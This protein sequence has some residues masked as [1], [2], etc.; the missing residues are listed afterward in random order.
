MEGQIKRVRLPEILGR[1]YKSFWESKARYLVCKGGRGSKKSC[2]A[3]LKLIYNIMQYPGSNGLVVRRYDVDH[4]DSTF[5]Q[6]KWAINRLGVSHLWKATTSPIKLVY[7]PTGQSII[8]RGLNDPQSIA[9]AT[10]EK[11]YL[12]FVWLEEAYQVMKESDFDRL[13]L[14]IRGDIPAPLFKQFIITFNPWNEKHWLKSRFFDEPDRF[15]NS[16]TT[17][18]LQNEFLGEDDI[19]LF[20]LM[21]E[22][23]PGRYAVEGLGNWGTLEGAIYSPY[24][25]DPNR[26]IIDDPIKY[27]QDKKLSLVGSFVGIDWG[28]GKSANTAVAVGITRDCQEVIVL[29]EFYTKEEMDPETLFRHHL[30]FLDQIVE[31]YGFAS[32]FPDNAEGM[33]VN[34]LKNT[35]AARG[36]RANIRPC[37]KFPIND[38]IDLTNSLFAMD[39]LKINVK[40]AHLR[41]AFQSAIW[42]DK[43]KTSRLDNGTSNIDSLDAFEYSLCTMMKNLERAGRLKKG[44]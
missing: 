27:I 5:A 14:S 24:V 26:F 34:G 35:A 7:L 44:A 8:F 16:M 25:N 19:A 20:D 6:L 4:R 41:E 3:S 10:V 18:Y 40:C 28:H 1:G 23:S 13:D 29:D 43:L 9:S 37:I 15:T 42:D 17:T 33:L 36:L 38:R 12:C 11:G 39:R 30:I 22:K 32:V 31:D 21:K 2:T